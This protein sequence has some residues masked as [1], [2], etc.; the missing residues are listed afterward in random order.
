M[1]LAAMLNDNNNHKFD[2]LMA[3]AWSLFNRKDVQGAVEINQVLN[4]QYANR[5]DGWY[6]TH[7]LSLALNKTTSAKEAISF[8]CQLEPK[9][10][11]WRLEQAQL[12]LSLNEFKAASDTLIELKQLSLTLS[13]HDCSRL[14][15]LHFQ[16]NQIQAAAEYYQ[17][18]V[19]CQPKEPVYWYNLA[20]IKRQLGQLEGACMC[21]QSALKLTPNYPDALS[22]LVDIR[23]A[24]GNITA[25][26][27]L[28]P[29]LFQRLSEANSAKQQVELHF[30]IGKSLES[31]KQYKQAFDH[32]K[33]GADL[34]R[35]HLKYDVGQDLATMEAIVNQFDGEWWQGKC[36]QLTASSGSGHE[37]DRAAETQA[38]RPIFILG[39]PRTGST[40]VERLLSQS[41][42]VASLGE[43]S[44]FT[45]SLTQVIKQQFGL[46][47]LSKR[48]FIEL[49]AKV[50]LLQV[51]R[52]YMARIT[53][54]ANT[55]HISSQATFIIDKL[56]LNFLSLG[57]IKKALPDAIIIE[58]QRNLMDTGWAIYKTLFEQAYPFSYQQTELAHYLT[59]YQS[60]MCHWRNLPGVGLITQQYESL[61]NDPINSGKA[62]FAEIGLDWRDDYVRLKNNDSAVNTASSAQVRQP[63]HNRS[64]QLWHHYERELQEMAGLINQAVR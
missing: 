54:K 9:N 22:L 24:E 35:H 33:V 5:A 58:T 3:Q 14:G 18:A 11:K 2:S 29:I 17:Q 47:A 27:E 32:F 21:L 45:Q 8:C 50:D 12:Y 62:L 6:F 42:D 36:D 31:M 39:L 61:V 7:R 48:Q 38:I 25:L 34:R 13:G 53:E 16:L 20:T 15:Q 63:I 43:L 19:E 51:G 57:L 46:K 26:T 55:S 1:S 37:G 4:R 23:A 40:M 59:A 49:S 52:V 60:L 64:V 28:Q 41:P 44:D 30:A 10:P 56:P